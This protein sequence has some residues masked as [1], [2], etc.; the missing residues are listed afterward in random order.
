MIAESTTNAQRDLDEVHF[1]SFSSYAT[2]IHTFIQILL[3]QTVAVTLVG[4]GSHLNDVSEQVVVRIVEPETFKLLP[5]DTVR[6]L[7]WIYE[8]V[9]I[10]ILY[11]C[12]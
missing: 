9:S 10:V 8:A 7:T 5:E 1:L 4:C 3:F 12:M 11:V 2:Y 6:C